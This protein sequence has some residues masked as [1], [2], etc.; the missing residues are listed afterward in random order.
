[1]MMLV[2]PIIRGGR[3]LGYVY[4][5]IIDSVVWA[6]GG[7]GISF[8]IGSDETGRPDPP[9][10]AE[11]LAEQFGNP[12]AGSLI[13]D[14]IDITTGFVFIVVMAALALAAFRLIRGLSLPI[15]KLGGARVTGGVLRALWLAITAIPKLLIWALTALVAWL[16][17]V[18]TTVFDT[19]EGAFGS[20]VRTESVSKWGED[21]PNRRQVAELYRRFLEAAAQKLVARRRSET[22]REYGSTISGMVP[23]RDPVDDLTDIFNEA[24][25]SLHPIADQDVGRAAGSLHSFEETLADEES[26]PPGD[27]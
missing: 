5:R 14:V 21:D 20:E 26:P 16:R 1:M 22:P 15:G 17:R 4:D 10:T 11:E 18:R 23:E 7:L 27:E 19:P 12:E 25:Y 6:A 3:A 2:V 13:A 9:D 8:R 24:R